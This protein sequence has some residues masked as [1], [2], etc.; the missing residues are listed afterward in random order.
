MG[1]FAGFT[2]ARLYK[3]FKGRARVMMI[4]MMVVIIMMIMVVM[5]MIV[6][7]MI[8]LVTYHIHYPSYLFCR[9]AMAEMHVAHC[10]PVSWHL[11][12]G[13]LRTGRARMG[14]WVS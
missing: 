9:Q 5:V 11:V 14:L 4:T 12:C 13:V 6:M 2:S 1:A 10:L 7:M 3:T 8:V